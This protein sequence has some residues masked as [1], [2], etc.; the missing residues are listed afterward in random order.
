MSDFK[1]RHFR[2]EV[3]LW[4]VRWYCRYGISIATLKR[5][6]VNAVSALITRRSTEGVA[7]RMV[8]NCGTDKTEPLRE[9]KTTRNP[10]EL[11]GFNY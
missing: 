4:A 8:W 1:G 2:G 3:I 11:G 7:G 5:C 6:S 10:D 9:P